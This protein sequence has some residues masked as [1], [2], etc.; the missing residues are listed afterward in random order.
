MANTNGLRQKIRDG[1]QLRIAAIQCAH[2]EDEMFTIPG[3]LDRGLFDVEQLPYFHISAGGEKDK[4][5]E[6]ITRYIEASGNRDIILY[7]NAHCFGRKVLDE[8]PDWAQ[9]DKSG[10][11]VSAYDSAFLACVNS[12]WRDEFL[13][14]DVAF[15]LMHPI[16]GIF[17][18][19]PLFNGGG[20]YCPACR[21]LFLEE[22]GKDIENADQTD[23][24]QFKSRHIGRILR[25]IRVLIDKSGKTAALYVNNAALSENVTGCSV[26]SVYP[27]VDFLGTEGGFMFYGDPNRVS[28]WK[29]SE[30]ARYLESKAYGKPYVIFCAGDHKPWSRVM[31]TADETRAMYATVAANGAGMWYGIHGKINQ[32]DTPGGRAAF[33]FNRFLAENEN[34]YA[35]TRRIADTALVWS[36]NTIN[37]MPE[38]VEKTDFT[39]KRDNKI[40]RASGSF[41]NEFH[42]FFDCLMRLHCQ[43]KTIDE[44]NII[45]DDLSAYKTVIL[46]NA[47]CLSDEAARGLERYVRGGGRLIATGATG[48]YDENGRLR[49]TPVLAGF[50]GM[51]GAPEPVSYNG[52][53]GYMDIA[54]GWLDK[55][56][57][58]QGIPGFNN[59]F[60]T[61][62]AVGTETLAYLREPMSGRYDDFREERFPCVTSKKSGAGT[63][64]YIAGDF[65]ATYF[66]HGVVDFKVMLK[67]LLAHEAESGLYIENA[68]ESVEVVRRS[69]TGGEILHFVNYTGAMRRPI[70]NVIPCKD[71]KINM[72]YNKPVGRVY[73]L[74]SKHKLPFEQTN[75]VLRFG[76]DLNGVY[77]AVVIT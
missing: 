12:A 47:V 58:I 69:F 10:S 61:T 36:K 60:K 68:Y 27:Y 77:G 57:N 55:N 28:L 1:R 46:P 19:G 15:A 2:G 30:S 48:F 42:G 14:K 26:D 3:I 50:I 7:L 59:A 5:D 24:R 4:P 38:S 40:L 29:T 75:G 65:G 18:D 45:T 21:G 71:I 8:H 11:A 70:E 44:D 52:G 9:Y 41:Q 49:D 54:A 13:F 51:A 32:F 22:F 34:Y 43:F 64:V 53:C 63:C 33:E 20:C 31:H 67:N 23:M 17:L 62:Y 56:T 6:K 25:D 16:G 76:F 35:N 37:A 74:W 39:D 72:N 66:N 73:E